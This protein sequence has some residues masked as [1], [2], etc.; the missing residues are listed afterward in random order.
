[1]PLKRGWNCHNSES[2]NSARLGR[3]LPCYRSYATLVRSYKAI[4]RINSQSG[5]GG[6]AYILLQE[7][8][9]D[10][11]KRSI[12]RSES[13]LTIG[14]T[15][16]SAN[17]V[18]RKSMSAFCRVSS[19]FPS[20]WNWSTTRCTGNPVD[21]TSSRLRASSFMKERKSNSKELETVLSTD[22]PIRSK[23]WGTSISN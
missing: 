22:L 19:I 12:R 2:D 8:G 9:Y 14:Q 3:S 4:I 21:P 5:K 6:V 18:W 13:G 11:P 15:N 20:R 16:S 1:M 23:N 7:Y 10:L 17:S